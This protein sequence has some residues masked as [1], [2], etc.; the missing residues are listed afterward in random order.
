MLNRTAAVLSNSTSTYESIPD[1][2]RSA[3]DSDASAEPFD[4]HTYDPGTY[5]LSP[6]AFIREQFLV[7]SVKSGEYLI[8]F[9]SLDVS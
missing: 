2:F 1:S 6:D 9:N 8:H 5:G 3:S 7:D 4:K